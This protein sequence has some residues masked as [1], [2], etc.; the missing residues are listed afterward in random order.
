LL[1]WTR[2]LAFAA[3]CF[4]PSLADAHTF[5][6]PADNPA[7]TVT[8]PDYLEPVDALRGAE[9]GVSQERTF[10]VSIEPLEGGELAAAVEQ[11]FKIFVTHGVL[12]EPASVKQTARTIIG[13]DAVDITFIISDG[14]E[15]AGFTVIKTKASGN[16]LGA[17][18]YGSNNGMKENAIALTSIIDSIRP[19]KK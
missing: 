8:I 4:L 16:F 11:G 14:V 18:Y 3:I 13:L 7:V 19:I 2:N 9:A 10:N 15:A 17:L 5:S 12:V 6:L 1:A